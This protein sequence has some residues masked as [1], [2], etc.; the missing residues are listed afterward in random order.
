MYKIIKKS[1]HESMQ[2]TISEATIDL[3]QKNAQLEQLQTNLKEYEELHSRLLT[4]L[5]EHEKMLETQQDNYVKIIVS[6]DLKSITPVIGYRSDCFENLFQDGMLDDTKE[7]SK[8]AIQLALMTIAGEALQQLIESF[9]PE[10]E[11]S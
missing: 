4:K 1:T 5:E 9:E 8:F 7:G 6:P 11:E 2:R 10:P 3:E